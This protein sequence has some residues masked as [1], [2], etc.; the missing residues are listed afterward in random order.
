MQTALTILF[1]AAVSCVAQAFQVAS[2]HPLMTD[3][4]RQVGG[5]KVSIVEIVKPGFNL[6]E[7]EPR[8][9]DLRQLNTAKLIFASGKGLEPYL[10]GLRDSLQPDQQLIEVGES[11]PSQT[12][13][14]AEQV[15]SCCPDH[16]HGAVDPHW[17]HNVKH[18]RRAVRAVEKALSTAD[19]NNSEY[20]KSRSKELSSRYRKLDAWVHQEVAQIPKDQRHL[21]T[22]HAAFAY[23]CKAYG[24][25]ATY[26]QGLSSR[27][28]IGATQL[29]DSIRDL[30][31]KQIRTIFPETQANPKILQQ[32]TKE[33]GA[34]VGKPLI[35]EGSTASYE[36]MIRQNVSRIVSGLKG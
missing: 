13:S 3:L 12:V 7:F 33:I 16:S 5:D 20:Y 9:D 31:E 26:V 1:L 8:P 21:V 30:R 24:F 28:E 22:A 18:M 4:V 23:F 17:W 6:H 25:E 10:D 27:G 35:A 15:Y 2:L 19:P 32:I 34:R 11:I 36:E 14:A 29:A